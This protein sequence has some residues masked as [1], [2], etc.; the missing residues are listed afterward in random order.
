MRCGNRRKWNSACSI[1]ALIRPNLS[2]IVLPIA[3]QR[4]SQDGNYQY[5]GGAI[6]AKLT[7]PIESAVR[8]VFQRTLESIN[9][10]NGY[11]GCDVIVPDRKPDR[12]LIVEINPRLT[13]SYIG[14]RQLCD[15]N[16]MERLLFP[17]RSRDPVRWQNGRVTF[18]AG[19]ECRFDPGT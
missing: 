10:L 7:P 4:L 5:L 14:Y 3:E 6:P 11:V 13:T 2:P 19:G 17:D 18:D 12:P 9:G 16:L 1:A 15:D 8:Q